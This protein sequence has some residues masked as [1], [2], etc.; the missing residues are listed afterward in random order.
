MNKIQQGIRRRA[1]QE[2]VREFDINCESLCRKAQISSR[3]FYRWRLGL[4]D[5]RLETLEALEMAL[6]LGVRKAYYDR[7]GSYLGVDQQS[8][9]PSLLQ[10]SAQLDL[11]LENDRL[12]ASELLVVLAPKVY[13]LL[14]DNEQEQKQEITKAMSLLSNLGIAKTPV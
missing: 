4:Q 5:V 7:A 1:I 2:I 8:S 11:K 10:L 3:G 14:L 13:H 12:L 6:P 9:Q